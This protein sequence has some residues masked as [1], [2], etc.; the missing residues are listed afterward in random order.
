MKKQLFEPKDYG[1]I[2]DKDG[3]ILIKAEG[4]VGLYITPTSKLH[5]TTKID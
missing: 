4:N 3:N 2:K 1:V 5:I